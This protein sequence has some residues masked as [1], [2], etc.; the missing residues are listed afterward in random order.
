MKKE[1]KIHSVLP[2]EKTYPAWLK[3]LSL[4]VVA[5]MLAVV[6]WCLVHYESEYLWK[7]QELNLFLDTPLFLEQQQVVSGWLLTWLGC[8]LTEFF[9]HPVLGVAWLVAW[10][11]LLMWLT[12]KAFRVPVKWAVALLVPVALLLL[13]D[14]DLGYW[15]YYLKLR[16]HFFAATIGL[17]IAVAAV[18]GLP[19]PLRGRGG[20]G[21]SFQ[22]EGGKGASYLS[23]IRPLYIIVATAVLYPLIGFYG[24]LAAV[25]MG[26]MVWRMDD[27]T[28]KGRL[29]VTASAVF[30]A[31]VIPQLFYHFVFCQTNMVNIYWTGLPLFLFT[32]ETTAYYVP[33]YL[34]VACYVVLAATYRRQRTSE[35][36]RPWL[37]ALSQAAL[38]AVLVWGVQRYWYKDYNFHKE[39]RMQRCMEQ[40]DWNGLLAEAADQQDEPTRAIIMMRNLALFRLG[41]QGDEMYHYPAGAKASDTPLPVNMTQVVGRSIYYH[42]GM[43]NFCYRWCLEDGVEFGWRAEYLKYMV[44]C[45][46]VNGEWPVA[47]KYIDL[48]KHTRYHREW[49]EHYAAFLPTPGSAQSEQACEEALRR[50]PEFAPIFHLHTYD[51]QLASDNALVEYFLMNYFIT[52]QSD[53]PLYQEQTLLSALWLK[54]IQAFWPRFFEYARLHP[55]KHM[56]RHFQEAAYLY[57]HLEHEVDISG[58]PF[59]QQ[60]R[61]DYDA[62]MALA[63]QCQGMT[64]EQMKPIFYPRFGKT[65]YY[66]YFLIRNQ[67]LY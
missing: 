66:E 56:P 19:R 55:D 49:A 31:V 32:E 41:R 47:R 43:L 24:L 21:A 54:D 52:H 4:P 58:M 10:W 30:S 44:R 16:G 7:A 5:A 3:W 26:I 34:L 57:G 42:Y 36:Q 13:T 17:T 48:L 60:V 63:Q 53:D 15:I 62:F 45:S 50:D 61:N 11:A 25:L 67:K 28:L 9:Y 2:K 6:A 65:F 22:K 64:E 33:Y 23:I 59:D 35:V 1:K 40:H 37:W 39:L 18:W 27:M 8:W 12:G 38:L 51:D 29:L 14:V 46:L 20:K